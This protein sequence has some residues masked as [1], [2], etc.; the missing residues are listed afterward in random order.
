MQC[1]MSA[2]DPK[3]TL[4]PLPVCWFKSVRWLVLS[5]G[6]IN[7]AARVHQLYRRCGGVAADCAGAARGFDGKEGRDAGRQAEI[8]I[9][10][11]VCCRTCVICTSIKGGIP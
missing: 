3:R 10:S 8:G 11:W 6:G 7:E 1:K 9:N 4:A 5:L 2:Y